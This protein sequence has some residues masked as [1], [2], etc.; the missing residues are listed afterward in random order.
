MRRP[1]DVAQDQS[2][3]FAMFRR[4]LMENPRQMSALAPSS[5]RLAGAM[6]EGFGLHTGPVVE[7][8]P[9]T[10]SITRAILASGLPPENLTL[11]ELDGE[12]AC[13]LR[14]TLPAAVTIHVAPA[15]D[16]VALMRGRLPRGAAAVI[17]GLPLL[18]MPNEV[19]RDI[20]VAAL[21]LLAPGAPLV[22][23]TY[24]PR[25]PLPDDLIA[26]LDLTVEKGVRILRNLPP[27]RIYRFRQAA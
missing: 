5:R 2:S 20:V 13:H 17:S 6:A 3:D 4:R 19:R 18:S 10:G 27:A 14:T 22:Q 11:F 1:T 21:A 16:A 15:Q 26:A 25:P 24:G 12:L 7:F 8:G 23:F 9:G